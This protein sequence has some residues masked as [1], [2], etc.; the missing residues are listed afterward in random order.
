ML[1][2]YRWCLFAEFFNKALQNAFSSAADYRAVWFAYIYYL[3]RQLDTISTEDQRWESSVKEIRDVIVMAYQ[4]LTDCS[5]ALMLCILV[6][7]KRPLNYKFS[8]F[9]NEGDPECKL[10]LW[11]ARFE[12]EVVHDY[13][14]FRDIWTDILDAGHGTTSS[15]WIRYITMEWWENFADCIACH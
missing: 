15:Y 4:N 8:G 10:S 14:Q 11:W 12:A 3:R 5:Y 7:E 9:R 1:Q 6:G 2:T 13:K